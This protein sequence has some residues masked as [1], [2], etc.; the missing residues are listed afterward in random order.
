MEPALLL[1]LAALALVDSTSIG[2]L[3][4]PLWLMLAPGRVR[5]DRVLLFLG[6][7]AGAYLLLG[8][9]L[10][11]GAAQLLDPV[12]AA[13]ES[14]AGRI[15]PLVAGVVLVVLGVTVEP[16]TQAGKERRRAARAARGPG[17]LARWRDRVRGDADGGGGA[18]VGLAVVAVG[19]EA[20]SMVPYLAAIALLA[21]SGLGPVPTVA[22]L[23]GYC[24]VMV[25]PALV[26]LALRAALHDRL[27]PALA[28]VEAWLSRT[29]GEAV[30]WVLFLLGLYL[31]AGAFPLS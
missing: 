31:V 9:A 15:V 28:R 21:T 16:W 27:T 20:A 30:A 8:A 3:V 12:S 5:V 14:A 1:S 18:V 4:L 7:V 17:R 24:L 19:V 10:A 13:L 2:T 6:S 25:L 11:L 22:V 23:A 26:L 29:S